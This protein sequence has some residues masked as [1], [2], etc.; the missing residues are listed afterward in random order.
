MALIATDNGGSFKPVP[1]GVHLACCYR[2][3][4]LGTQEVDYQGDKKLQRK[5]LI[6]WELHGEDETGEP[7]TTD[8]GA[9]MTISKRY[10]LSLSRNAK[11][12]S[13]LESWR[14]RSFTDQELRGFDVSQLL[15]K[16]CMVNITHDQRDGKTYSNIASISPVP[17]MLRNAKPD[18]INTPQLFD[19]TEPDA[20]LYES[21][22]ERLRE[23]IAN[24]VEWRAR[25]SGPV[26]EAPS[27]RAATVEDDDIPF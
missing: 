24:S 7:L 21:F 13:D 26:R 23:L 15:G 3:I 1:Q 20:G 18:P 27:Q 16:W 10:T 25:R 11:M 8:D 4:D 12:R 14:G 19:V 22:H 17:A 2:V 5:V 9:P 6:G